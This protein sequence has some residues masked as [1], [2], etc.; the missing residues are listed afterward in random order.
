[1]SVSKNPTLNTTW[2]Y[3]GDAAGIGAMSQPMIVAGDRLIVLSGTTNLLHAINIYDGV[4]IVTPTPPPPPPPT[5]PPSTTGFPQACQALQGSL[6]T[7]TD[8]AIFYL[9]TD[10]SGNVSIYAIQLADGSTRCFP[11]PTVAAGQQPPAPMPWQVAAPNAIQLIGS[12]GLV[13][14]ISQGFTNTTVTAYSTVDGS[15]VWPKGSNASNGISISQNN[16]GQVA[17]Q[18][19]AFF[20]VSGNVLYANNLDF[21]DQRFPKNPPPTSPPTPPPAT[22][23]PNEQTAPLVGESVVVCVGN[24]VFGFDQ[25]KGGYLGMAGVWDPTPGATQPGW[26]TSSEP[27]ASPTWL[28]AISEDLSWIAALSSDGE[29]CV[30]DATTGAP[31]CAPLTGIQSGIPTVAGTDICITASGSGIVTFVTLDLVGHSLGQPQT[32]QISVAEAQQGNTPPPLAQVPPAIGNGTAFIADNTGNISAVPYSNA[33]AAYFNG[34]SS[35]AITPGADQYNFAFG[36]GDFTVESWVHS[37][38]GGEILSSDPVST[39]GDSTGAQSFAFRFNVGKAGELRF[40]VTS[41]DGIGSA[42]SNQ[43]LVRTGPTSVIDGEWHHVAIRRQAGVVSFFLDGISQPTFTLQTRAQAT[44]G[45]AAVFQNGQ[46]LNPDGSLQ[47]NT[48]SPPAPAAALSL[49]P[50]QGLTIGGYPRVGTISNWNGLLRELRIWDVG[51]DAATIQNHMW[52]ALP[53]NLP[54]LYGNWHLSFTDPADNAKNDFFDASTEYPATFNGGLNVNTDLE[55]DDSAFPFTLQQPNLQWPYSSSWIAAGESPVTAP[56]AISEDGVVCFATNNALYGIR[57]TDATRLWEVAISSTDPNGSKGGCSTP[58]AWGAWFFVM[59]DMYGLI[60]IDTQTGDFSELPAF[61]GMAKPG[62]GVLA[63]PVTDGHYLA[64]ANPDGTMWILDLTQSGASAVSYSTAA[65]PGDLAMENGI[66]YTVT[67]GTALHAVTPGNNPPTAPV[68]IAVSSS[69]FCAF[70]QFVFCVQNNKLVAAAAGLTSVGKQA[71]PIPGS[72]NQGSQMT[73]M[74]ADADANLLVVTDN[75]GNVYGLNFS[76]GQNWVQSISGPNGTAGGSLN[77]PIIDGRNVFCTSSSGAVAALDGRTGNLLGLFYVPNAVT[78]PPVEDAGVVYFGCAD[79]SSG[80]RDGALH[81]VIFG[82]TYGLRLGL[83][84]QDQSA[85]AGY[86]A[87]QN[88][89]VDSFQFDGGQECC[90]EAWINISPGGGG[91]IFSLCP[92]QSGTQTQP[93]VRLW[94]DSSGALNFQLITPATGSDWQYNLASSV[95]SVL[96]DGHWHHVAVSCQNP[97]TQQVFID[98]VAQDY[99]PS[100][101]L[102][103]PAQLATQIVAYLG[104]DAT[105]ANNTPA[106][107]FTGL[108]GEVR[109]WRTYMVA[110]EISSRMHDKLRGDEA[111]LLAY[112]NFDTLSVDDTSVQKTSNDGSSTVQLNGTITGSATYWLTDLCF[113]A[114][115]YP[116]FTTKGALN[117]PPDPQPDPPITSYTLTLTVSQANGAPLAGQPVYFW[118]VQH[119]DIGEPQQITVQKTAVDTPQRLNGLTPGT[120]GT[121]TDGNNYTDTTDSSGSISFIVTTIDMNNGPSF[122]LYAAC[123][124]GFMPTNER[125]HVN[126]L[127]DNQNLAKPV[128]PTINAQSQLLQDYHYSPGSSIDETR[129]RNTY[130]V[131]LTVRNPD[132]SARANEQ[133]EIYATDFLTIEVQGQSYS[134]NTDNNATF[135]TDGEGELTLIVDATDVTCPSLSIWAGFMNPQARYTVDPSEDAHNA[136]SN[137]QAAPA[138]TAANPSPQPGD[139]SDPAKPTAGY[140]MTDPNRKILWTKSGATKGAL[141]NSEDNGQAPSMANAVTH[142]MAASQPA[143]ANGNPNVTADAVGVRGSRRATR[144]QEAMAR[145]NLVRLAAFDTQSSGNGNAAM[146]QPMKVPCGNSV[147][148]LPTMKHINRRRPVTPENVL[149]SIQGVSKGS[150]GFTFAYSGL[151][152]L[153]VNYV[154][155]DDAKTMISSAAPKKAKRVARAAPRPMMA[156]SVLDDLWDDVTDIADD[157]YDDLQQLTI[158]ITDTI[159]VL[160]QVAD[161]IVH[162]VVHSIEEAVAA[163]SNFFE[164]LYVDLVKLIQFLALLF[165]WDAILETHT[166]LHTAFTSVGTFMSNTVPD[167]TAISAMIDSLI[168]NVQGSSAPTF[169]ASAPGTSATAAQQTPS[170]ASDPSVSGCNSPGPKMM[171]SKTKDNQGSSS[172]PSA[173]PTPLGGSDDGS[174]DPMAAILTFAAQLPSLNASDA[175]PQLLSLIENLGKDALGDAQGDVV[176]ALTSLVSQVASIVNTIDTEID[177]PFISELYCWITDAPYL[178]ILDLLCLVFAVMVHLVY[179]LITGN[180]FASD[181]PASLL[182]AGTALP[183]PAG[184]GTQNSALA[185]AA[186]R[187]RTITAM[188][189]PSGYDYSNPLAAY[190]KLDATWAEVVYVCAR[191]ISIGCSSAGDYI[192]VGIAKTDANFT[193][194]NPARAFFQCLQGSFGLVADTFMFVYSTP[195]FVATLLTSFETNHLSPADIDGPL[196]TW[197]SFY[198]TKNAAIFAFTA[199]GDAI[200]TFAGIYKVVGGLSSLDGASEALLPKNDPGTLGNKILNIQRLIGI[201]GLCA[202]GADIY[203]I[204]IGPEYRSSKVGTDLS[205]G[206]GCLWGRDMLGHLNMLTGSTFTDMGLA[207]SSATL[208]QNLA[209]LRGVANFGGLILHGIGEFAFLLPNLPPSVTTS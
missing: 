185:V 121:I 209:I 193:Y 102:T 9:N 116:Y 153:Q 81:S 150:V 29:L 52:Q 182:P 190:G 151:G 28:A 136:L 171:Y 62:P 117:E 38:E 72:Q 122:D 142:V 179:A 77:P 192:C 80:K 196:G 23:V 187:G 89:F 11:T 108:I 147:Q 103:K 165:E 56:P 146:I 73:G 125:Y 114:P 149:N 135:T 32:Y 163:V 107:P 42:A 61:D 143:P 34:Q 120:L 25:I 3:Q 45:K 43:D 178:S 184:Q 197:T 46:A 113:E 44:G 137:V 21:G 63:A 202:L 203:E 94:I 78:T 5:P 141:L 172:C 155:A 134:I 124:N 191:L 26:T 64:A 160:I 194:P 100:Q 139:A 10:G 177:I 33:S 131:T 67:G 57:K 130:R 112:W 19:G 110:S 207:K 69:I 58:I 36:T 24:G 118:Y 83:N 164:Q 53:P 60:Q 91:E 167:A 54:H 87:I 189:N 97:T 79:P 127:L 51:L 47:L 71:V 152:T 109:L 183:V 4:E 132:N 148:A 20:Y 75:Q 145:P 41:T 181:A 15:V 39:A 98:G 104:A 90:V 7:I 168:G 27:P 162:A 37:S 173:N 88:A 68:S 208:I 188:D 180:K 156:M 31:L 96:V 119:A 59:T 50:Q 159:N 126:V 186:P 140:N 92:A 195:T 18:N 175:G 199:L 70:G 48:V 2:T 12:P 198:E 133:L 158:L 111:G 201:L 8:G 74:A 55:I 166:L 154:S 144:Y 157:I 138:P 1:M 99:T 176:T 205:W 13:V 82:T 14:V 22:W 65:N 76:L 93:G 123:G 101:T 105:E 85:G 86:A 169:P 66:V 174:D 106:N 35:I 129:I 200:N 206:S 17:V 30:I 40:A 16:I 6:Y 161:Q 204:I 95:A 115:N 84:P 170:S 128:P 49:G